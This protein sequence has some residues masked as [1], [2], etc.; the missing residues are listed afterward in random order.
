MHGFF[1]Q[2]YTAPNLWGQICP[3]QLLFLWNQKRNMVEKSM[4]NTRRIHQ[5]FYK[6]LFGIENTCYSLFKG[7]FYI[8]YK[9]PFIIYV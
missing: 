4:T 6:L 9:I 3:G 7:I 2:L 1:L 8:G 5:I